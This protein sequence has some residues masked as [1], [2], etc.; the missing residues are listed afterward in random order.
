MRKITEVKNLILASTSPR[1]KELLSRFTDNFKIMNSLVDEDIKTNEPKEMVL[2]L[3]LRK[4]LA[5]LDKVKELDDILIISA[6]TIVYYDEILEKP[7][8]KADALEMLKKISNKKHKVMT[9][10]CVS[11]KEKKVIEYSETIVKFRETTEDELIEYIE[12]NEPMDKSGSY[13]INGIASKFIEYIEGDF[14]TVVGFP[15]NV[16]DKILR[17]NFNISL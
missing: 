5:V 8:S 1:R 6:D 14:Y 12:T 9:G 17:E 4:N 10:I 15:I 3:A 13:A 2:S 11:N 7:K 16:L